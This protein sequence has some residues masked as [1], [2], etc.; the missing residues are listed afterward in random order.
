MSELFAI[1]SADPLEKMRLAQTA[2]TMDEQRRYGAWTGLSG[3]PGGG[4]PGEL[5]AWPDDE[6]LQFVMIGGWSPSWLAGLTFLWR[7]RK[8]PIRIGAE[9]LSGAVTPEADGHANWTADHI[10]GDLLQILLEMGIDPVGRELGSSL[11]RES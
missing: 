3:D 4:G 7:S 2:S 5:I 9:F 8:H 11:D 10:T 6:I 1:S